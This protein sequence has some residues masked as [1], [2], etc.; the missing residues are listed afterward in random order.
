MQAMRLSRV[1][2]ALA[3]V[4]AA[5]GGGCHRTRGGGAPRAEAT[6]PLVIRN[7]GVFDITIYAL[8]SSGSDARIRLGMATGSST[9]RIGV[10]RRAFQPTG[11]LVLMLHAIGA[12]SSWVTPSI[13]VPE[14]GTAH[15]DIMS[16][17]TGDVSRSA[18]YALA[19]TSGT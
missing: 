16:G 7:D 17:P 13:V 6:V 18:F 5:I 14:G 4:G 3:I 2:G 11:A 8:P 12:R 10:P 19:T 15:L 1:F 9:M